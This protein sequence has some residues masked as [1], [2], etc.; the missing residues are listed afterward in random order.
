MPVESVFYYSEYCEHS[1]KILH[2]LAKS[3]IRDTINFISIDKRNTKQDNK[4]YILLENGTE[5]ILPSNITKVPALLLLNKGHNVIF[6]NE[7]VSYLEP[8]ETEYT[9]RATMQNMEPLAFS[10]QE[11]A[12]S[13]DYYLSFIHL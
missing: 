4:T 9:K 2:M 11:M 6:G 5:I 1:K 7:I 12:G 8:K 3:Q 13:S 10:T